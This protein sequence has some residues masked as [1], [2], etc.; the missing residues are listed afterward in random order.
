M[1]HKKPLLKRLF[2][3]IFYTHLLLS[4]KY[5]IT[6]CLTPMT[7]WLTLDTK[8]FKVNDL[9]S[10]TDSLRTRQEHQ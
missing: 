3:A 6:V 4:L 5:D 7:V 1:S 2:L 9:V 8:Y 10:N